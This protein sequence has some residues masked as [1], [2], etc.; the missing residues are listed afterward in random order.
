LVRSTSFSYAK[1]TMIVSAIMQ[2]AIHAFIL[3][4]RQALAIWAALGTLALAAFVIFTMTARREWTGVAR[5][6]AAWLR[7]RKSALT[8]Q[9]DELSRYAEELAVAAR[10]AARTAQR[11]RDEWV[12]RDRELAQAWDGFIEAGFQIRRLLPAE[13]FQIPKQQ[14]TPMEVVDRERH[15]H[16]TATQ[17]YH[18]DDIGSEQLLDALHRR[19]GWD[20]CRHPAQQE[21]VLWRIIWER[22]RTAYRWAVA[23]ER[24]AWRDAGVALASSLS[25]RDEALTAELASDRV[26]RQLAEISPQ[27]RA[28]RRKL[29]LARNQTRTRPQI[30]TNAPA[31]AGA[32]L[33]ES[34]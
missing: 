1:E 5:A 3:Q 7:H 25:L 22:R 27:H 15:L 17:A 12:L 29:V 8:K 9:H 19:N 21:I 13:A 10:R 20:P 14:L 31:R 6:G 11:T 24:R 18:R 34:H 28:S 32:A 4:T 26:Y 2:P 16:R 23:A 30:G 33:G